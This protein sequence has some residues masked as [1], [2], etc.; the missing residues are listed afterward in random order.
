MPVISPS[1]IPRARSSCT[2]PWVR[3]YGTSWPALANSTSPLTGSSTRARQVTNMC[4]G[5][6]TQSI[7]L[8]WPRT[9]PG[10]MGRGVAEQ[11]VCAR[12]DQRGGNAL[13]GDVA[14]H[15]HHPAVRQRDEVVE[16]TADRP[17]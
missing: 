7:S 11:R 9:L 3:T 14:D 4:A 15:E 1:G 8:T 5:M 16:V 10:E 12:H 6:S 2:P 13:V 17:G